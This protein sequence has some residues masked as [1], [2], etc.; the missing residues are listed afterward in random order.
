[1]FIPDP[2]YYPSLISD[3]GSHPGSRIQ[4]QQQKRGRKK[5]VAIPFFVTTNF[6]KLKII[7]FLNAEEKKNLAQLLRII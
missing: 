6:T 7:L 5:I 2:N 4:K 3:P 1:M